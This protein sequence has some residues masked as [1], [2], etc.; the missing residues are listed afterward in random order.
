MKYPAALVFAVLVW[1]TARYLPPYFL[2]SRKLDLE[3][4]KVEVQNAKHLTMLRVLR[5]TTSSRA[6]KAQASEGEASS[7]RFY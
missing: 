5:A 1:S 7:E 4:S 3:E 2:E 6:P